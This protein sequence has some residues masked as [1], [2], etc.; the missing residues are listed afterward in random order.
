MIDSLAKDAANYTL[1][2]G[3]AYCENLLNS[4]TGHTCILSFGKGK[5]ELPERSY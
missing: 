4:L 5:D 2:E 1:K 3:L